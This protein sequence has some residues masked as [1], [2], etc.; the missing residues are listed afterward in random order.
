[1]KAK[2]TKSRVDETT[3]P[4]SKPVIIFDTE[5]AGFVLEVTPAGREGA[6]DCATAWAGG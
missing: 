6:T 1:M 4:G 3:A 5:L 2:I